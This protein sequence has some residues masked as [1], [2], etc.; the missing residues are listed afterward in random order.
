MIGMKF[1]LHI[2]QHIEDQN[3]KGTCFKIT[4]PKRANKI[5]LSIKDKNGKRIHKDK[6]LESWKEYIGEIFDDNR[7]EMPTMSNIEMPPILKG[8]IESALKR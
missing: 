7:T 4:L 5:S 6:I 8:E 2:V 3:S 1:F